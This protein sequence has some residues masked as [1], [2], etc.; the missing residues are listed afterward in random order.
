MA[1]EN[2]KTSET[3]SLRRFLYTV[4]LVIATMV[5]IV[6]AMPNTEQPR[7]TYVINEPWISAQLISPG[8]ILIQK[9]AKQVEQEQHEALRNEYMPYYRYD[10]N[11]GERQVKAFLEKYGEGSK[12]VS[13]YC[14]H[15]VAEEMRKIYA[16]GIMP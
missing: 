1:M 4:A 2:V 8:E 6:L 13:A 7:L 11:I 15:L 16:T 3:T 9:D 14:I 5:L 12:D 10:E